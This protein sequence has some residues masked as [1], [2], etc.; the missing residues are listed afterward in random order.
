MLQVITADRIIWSPISDVVC[1]D[2][3]W[4][5]KLSAST[6]QH[7]TTVCFRDTNCV[8][9]RGTDLILFVGGKSSILRV[10]FL[11]TQESFLLWEIK[12]ISH[13]RGSVW[14]AQCC[15][16]M[17]QCWS[18]LNK[19]HCLIFAFR[20]QTFLDTKLHRLSV[21]NHIFLGLNNVTKQMS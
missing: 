13:Y 4:I 18:V 19:S 9:Q 12:S 21:R 6:K 5:L 16:S 15:I 10:H 7:N 1:G 20:D 8:V 2:M 17:G 3:I 11:S 14:K